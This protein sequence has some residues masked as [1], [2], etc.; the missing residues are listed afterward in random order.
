MIFQI[1]VVVL[2]L[3][4]VICLGGVISSV[5]TVLKHLQ[6]RDAITLD[7]SEQKQMENLYR[8]LQK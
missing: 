4:I 6:I 3:L 8:E 5:N 2:M 1:I 7:E